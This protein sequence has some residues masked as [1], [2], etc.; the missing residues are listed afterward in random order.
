MGSVIEWITSDLPHCIGIL[1]DKAE[2]W[3]CSKKLKTP[4]EKSI[5]MR[6]LAKNLILKQK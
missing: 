2:L 4:E 5:N 6:F 3:I 1:K